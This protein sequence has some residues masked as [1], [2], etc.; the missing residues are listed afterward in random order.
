[1]AVGPRLVSDRLPNRQFASAAAA[2]AP[3]LAALN[4]VVARARPSGPRPALLAVG[5]D[6][7]MSARC[8]PTRREWLRQAQRAD[9]AAPGFGD[10]KIRIQSRKSPVIMI[11][12]GARHDST[13]Q[14]RR[15][16]ALSADSASAGS[17]QLRARQRRA[18]LIRDAHLA[19]A[20]LDSR[21]PVPSPQHVHGLGAPPLPPCAGVA[22]GRPGQSRHSRPTGASLAIARWARRP[23]V[24]HGCRDRPLRC[25]KRPDKAVATGT[26]PKE[27]RRERAGGVLSGSK[28]HYLMVLEPPAPPPPSPLWIEGGG[29]R[30]SRAPSNDFAAAPRLLYRSR[31][32]F[33]ILSSD[34]LV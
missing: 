28:P 1:M 33:G 25:D 20:C 22:H 23:P 6:A 14:T 18:T 4:E 26:Q 24:R 10:M 19:D 30:S 3:R 2:Q 12:G 27:G 13:S 8:R 15:Q 32:P 7:S 17:R 11:S 21:L 5:S 34:R 31:T 29:Q 9:S 16:T